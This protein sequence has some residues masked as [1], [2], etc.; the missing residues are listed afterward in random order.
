M[1]RDHGEGDLE[2]GVGHAKV[3]DD[4]KKI[5]GGGE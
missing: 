5:G 4:R 1:K 3:V 2:K